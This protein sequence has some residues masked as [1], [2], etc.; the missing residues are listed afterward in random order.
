MQLGQRGRVGLR[1]R[2]EVGDDQRTPLGSGWSEEGVKR[3]KLAGRYCWAETE[4]TKPRVQRAF[5]DFIRWDDK[6]K[7]N[8][9]GKE[10]NFDYFLKGFKQ[11]NSNS[12]LNLSNQKQCSSMNAAINSYTLLI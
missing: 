9:R 1:V 7:R 2:P 11:P 12:S 3:A 6:K 10:R 8:G 4:G 5:Q